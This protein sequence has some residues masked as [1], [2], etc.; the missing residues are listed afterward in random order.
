[1]RKFDPW[2]VAGLATMF[3]VALATTALAQAPAAPEVDPASVSTGL[4]LLAG[5]V[6]VVRARRAGK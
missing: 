6:L 1:M 5:S 3:I 4:A 2:G